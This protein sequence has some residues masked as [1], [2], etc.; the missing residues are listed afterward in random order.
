V[1]RALALQRALCGLGYPVATDGQAG[2]ATAAAVAACLA[3]AQRAAPAPRWTVYLFAG[4][5]V[6]S[7]YGW[8]GAVA[9]APPHL[10]AGID[11]GLHAGA[12]VQALDAGRVVQAGDRSDGYGVQVVLD[13][14]DGTGSRYAHLSALLVAAGQT[15]TAGE[16]VG[17]VGS[18]GRS[19][20]PH[21]HLE[22][23][24]QGRPVDPAGWLAVVWPP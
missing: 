18:T 6:T 14:G 10:H 23:L 11:L 17:F 16:V 13:H 24:A 21:L 2:P 9:G 4:V 7:G 22:I 15:V 5:R 19:T 20:G 8:R 12:P 3:A 1:S